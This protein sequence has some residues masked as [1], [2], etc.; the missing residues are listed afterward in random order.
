MVKKQLGKPCGNGLLEKVN[1]FPRNEES[2]IKI[3]VSP[4]VDKT[5]NNSPMYPIG[6][7][8]FLQYRFYFSHSLQ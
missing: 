6:G 7:I 5:I 2:Y 4:I 3:E 1:A 8:A